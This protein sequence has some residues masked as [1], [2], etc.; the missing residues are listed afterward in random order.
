MGKDAALVRERFQTAGNV[1]KEG[2]I[3]FMSGN[4]AHSGGTDSA[5]IVADL[6]R[7]EL[8][9]WLTVGGNLRRFGPKD[10]PAPMPRDAATMLQNMKTR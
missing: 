1:E 2:S 3:V 6:K 5:L 8:W 10:D 9:V 7:D 4:K